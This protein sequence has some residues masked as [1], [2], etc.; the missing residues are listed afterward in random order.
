MRP[1]R[2]RRWALAA[3]PI[4]AAHLGLGLLIAAQTPAADTAAPASDAAK[5]AAPG[6]DAAKPADS[7]GFFMLGRYR[8]L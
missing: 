1:T 8:L 2:T 4:L 7:G 6:A 5:P 3:T